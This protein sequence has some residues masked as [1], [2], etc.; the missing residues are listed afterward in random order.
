MATIIN[1]YSCDIPFINMCCH[2]HG[3]YVQEGYEFDIGLGES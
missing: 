2:D 3:I 1:E